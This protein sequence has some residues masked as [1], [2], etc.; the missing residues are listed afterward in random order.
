MTVVTHHLY[1]FLQHREDDVL[2][3]YEK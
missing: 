2:F 3:Y 1:R